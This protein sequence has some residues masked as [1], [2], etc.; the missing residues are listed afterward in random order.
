MNWEKTCQKII[1][2]S[3]YSLFFL[4]PLIMTP[5]NYE[6]FEYNKMMLVYLLTVVVVGAWFSKMIVSKKILLSRTPFDIPIILFFFSQVLSTVFSI[7]VHTSIWGYYSRFHGGLLSTISYLLL[8]YA[9]VS[10]FEKKQVI[11]LL[12]WLLVSGLLV[13]F[14]GIL[15]HFGIDAKYWVQDVKNRVFS[16]LGQPNWL[17]A[18][19]AIILPL[20]LAFIIQNKLKN[21]FI[22]ITYLLYLIS[23]I[24]SLVFTK[25]RSGIPSAVIG[26]A[27]FGFFFTLPKVLAIKKQLLLPLV[28]IFLTVI[29][30][31]GFWGVKSLFSNLGSDIAYITGQSNQVNV[32]VHTPFQGQTAYGSSSGD[33]RKVVWRGAFKIFQAY[34]ILGSGVETF[35]YSYYNFRPIEH[36]YLSEWDF[37]YNKA[38]NEY[39][40]FL[41]TTGAVGFGTY[42]LFIGWVIVWTLK[43]ISKSEFLISNQIPKSKTQL[44]QLG[45]LEIR[46]IL[47]ALFSGWITILITNFFGFS[48][49]PIALCFFLF[50]TFSYLL[51]LPDKK[52][53]EIL[54]L[55]SSILN[56]SQKIGLVVIIITSSYFLLSIVRLWYADTLFATGYRLDRQGY[57]NQALEPLQQ[58]VAINPGEPVFHDELSWNAA[59]IALAAYSQQQTDL[60]AQFGKLSLEESDKALKISPKHLNFLKTRVKIYLK[61]AAIDASFYNDALTYLSEAHKLAPTDPKL[62][63]NLGLIYYQLDP[64]TNKEKAREYLQQSLDMM[65]TYLD[66]KAALE[67]LSKQP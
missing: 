48:V 40:N 10:N 45:Q 7:D 53:N 18:W 2:Y 28:G 14:Y 41:A 62:V 44:D 4:V 54:N 3:F 65:P 60:A 61:L 43:Q 55:K 52:G 16:T 8:Y 25:S 57:F 49:V 59:N 39:F 34:P 56:Q 33:I 30:G 63:Y 27:I 50:P 1:E 5:W 13:S 17:A 20:P 22:L 23:Y 31:F 47:P 35:A 29:L 67:A 38:H 11:T 19:L 51:I 6:L 37:L 46:L 32:T 9:L 15:E 36:N 21:K 26:L 64:K 58:A 24:L 42:L 66:A 12:K